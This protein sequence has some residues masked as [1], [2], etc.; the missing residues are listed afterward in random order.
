[1]ALRL[2]LLTAVVAVLSQP[3]AVPPV[4]TPPSPSSPPSSWQHLASTTT[5]PA[6]RVNIFPSPSPSYFFRRLATVESSRSFIHAYSC[7]NLSQ[8]YSDLQFACTAE[9]S[10]HM[11]ILERRFRSFTH[12][13]KADIWRSRRHLNETCHYSRQFEQRFRALLAPL[14]PPPP[15]RLPRQAQLALPFLRTSFASIAR[16]VQPQLLAHVQNTLPD[17]F[18]ASSPLPPFPNIIPMATNLVFS[19]FRRL[20]LHTPSSSDLPQFHVD[21]QAEMLDR[22]ITAV[23]QADFLLRDWSSLKLSFY[24]MFQNRF[25]P[26]L[27]NI[28]RLQNE[29]RH[30][31][32]LLSLQGLRLLSTTTSSFLAA[33]C[34]YILLHDSLHIYVHLPVSN[35]PRL[36]AYEFIPTPISNIL[37]VAEDRAILQPPVP[38]IL[39]DDD[40]RLYSERASLSTCTRLPDHALL[41][42]DIPVLRSSPQDSCLLALLRTHVTNIRNYCPMQSFTG[43]FYA[44]EISQHR[45]FIYA[46]TPSTAAIVCPASRNIHIP[47]VYLHARTV[48]PT[49]VQQLPI[50]VGSSTVTIPSFCHI[51]LNSLTLYPQSV[52]V[53]DDVKEYTMPPRSLHSFSDYSSSHLPPPHTNHYGNFLPPSPRTPAFPFPFPP[54]WDWMLYVAIA[55][56]LSLLY[57]CFSLPAAFVKHSGG[58][59]AFRRSWTAAFRAL[60]PPYRRPTT[61]PPPCETADARLA[62]S[63]RSPPA[64]HAAAATPADASP[65]SPGEC[66]ACGVAHGASQ[67]PADAVSPAGPY[68]PPRAALADAR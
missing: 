27:F 65:T 10:L 20:I 50:P 6:G 32:Q 33:P 48:L 19:A 56:F 12:N 28:S 57:A 61:P 1:M 24:D 35:T 49:N 47:Q 63:C 66:S 60:L 31:S 4:I 30:L 34:S 62:C 40:F 51:S 21:A 54:L 22:A 2:C 64:G 45:F 7:F 67:R 39:I 8:L 36:T 14:P 41:C 15:S 53:D 46:A 68:A 55:A 42:S 59:F 23:E 16:S 37:P 5:A 17:M 38:I 25:P 18:T 43:S 29:A 58:H 9:Q 11:I 52:R 13:A 3:P 44:T 26:R